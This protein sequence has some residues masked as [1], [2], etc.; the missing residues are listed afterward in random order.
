MQPPLVR[1]KPKVFT[2]KVGG[3]GKSYGNFLYVHIPKGAE[4]ELGWSRGDIV[5]ILVRKEE[6]SLVL[7]RIFKVEG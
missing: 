7:K 4:T 6:D 1:R 2:A 3:R 5:Q